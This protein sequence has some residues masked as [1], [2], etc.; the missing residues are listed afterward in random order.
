VAERDDTPGPGRRPALSGGTPA[1]GRRL[2]E[3]GRRT[4][5]GLVDS[6]L[7]V[8]AERG[9]HAARV[10]DICERAS[11]S[12]GTFYLY[13]ASKEDL[14]GSLVDDVVVRMAELADT[15]PPVESG[16][17]GRRAL[18]SW[19]GDFAALYERYFPVIQAWN[20]A[21]AADPELARRGAEVLR[22]FIDRL[23]ERVEENDQVPVDDTAIGALAMVSMV[24]RSITFALG[25]LVEV[26]RDELLDHLAGILHVGLF[27]GRR[28]AS[29][30]TG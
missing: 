1:R 6:A 18:R 9:F 4:V 8:F 10:D 27:G 21:N 17:A 28:G 5:A 14:F 11:V 16:A 29:A 15:L 30:A 13:F 23:V 2:R 7:L 24:E 19:L 20:E 3:A 26:D 12:H 22:A 25:G